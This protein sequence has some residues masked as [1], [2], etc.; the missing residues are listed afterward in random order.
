MTRITIDI[1]DDLIQ[2]WGGICIEGFTGDE[3]GKP[4]GFRHIGTPGFEYLVPKDKNK[5]TFEFNIKTPAIK[6]GK[7]KN[8]GK[9][10]NYPIK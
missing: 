8:A 5:S 4:A 9:Q 1:R 10:F 2:H 7:R 3:K 6:K